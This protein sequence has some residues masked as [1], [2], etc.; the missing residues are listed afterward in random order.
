[1]LRKLLPLLA[2]LPLIA[3]TPAGDKAATGEAI[4]EGTGVGEGPTGRTGDPVDRRVGNATIPATID[5][6][7]EPRPAP[8]NS[9]AAANNSVEPALPV[10]PPR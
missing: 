2:A 3:C 8:G 4:A 9:P 10:D 6:G 1:M 5:E 7:L